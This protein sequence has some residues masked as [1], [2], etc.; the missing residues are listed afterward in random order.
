MDYRG[1]YAANNQEKED[2]NNDEPKYYEFGAHFKYEELY[3]KLKQIQEAQKVKN[4][5]IQRNIH[6]NIDLNNYDEVYNQINKQLCQKMTDIIPKNNFIQSRNIQP[7]IQSLSQKLTDI[8]QSQ[9]QN[10]KDIKHK[11]TKNKCIKSNLKTSKNKKH[12]IK[13]QTNNVLMPSGNSN[14]KNEPEYFDMCGSFK[15]TNNSRNIKKNLKGIIKKNNF[16]NTNIN[17][18]VNMNNN[19]HIN[20]INQISKS[21]NNNIISHTLKKFINNDIS[22]KKNNQV[23]SHSNNKTNKNNFINNINNNLLNNFTNKKNNNNNKDIIFGTII[24]NSDNKTENNNINNNTNQTVQNIIVKPNI[25]ISFI[26]NINASFLNNKM[27]RHSPKKGRSRNNKENSSKIFTNE[28]EKNENIT[29]NNKNQ[30]VDIIL[31]GKIKSI[32]PKNKNFE[33]KE[34][35]KKN[36]FNNFVSIN[37]QQK[38]STRLINNEKNTKKNIK[39]NKTLCKLR[40]NINSK[41]NN[42]NS[43][44]NS[45]SKDMVKVNGVIEKKSEGKKK[46]IILFRNKIPSVKNLPDKKERNINYNNFNDCNEYIS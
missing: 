42:N 16:A 36:L 12:L 44:N 43:N 6:N 31:C 26:N 18:N 25:N 24:D 20:H 13:K 14:N 8:V 3:D 40:N 37:D 38:I 2:D 10:Q 17:S 35:T 4:T 22:I 27:N 39:M 15:Q 46:K 29:V 45:N 11:I 32:S 9:S 28:K 1:L 41:K 21:K 5:K 33:V 7:L 23:I 30:N 34:K 19:T